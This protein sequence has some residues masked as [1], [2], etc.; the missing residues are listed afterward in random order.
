MR[1]FLI[2]MV[3]F[4]SGMG[5]LLLIPSKQEP[6]P[7]PWETTIMTDGNVKVF[8]IHLGK[9][10]YK[11]AQEIFNIYGKTAVFSQADHE[12]TV[13]AYFNSI[14]LGG[15][16]AKVVLNL[17]VPEQQIQVMLE[18]ATEAKL[19]P[20]GARRYEIHSDDTAHLLASPISAIT[21]IPSVRLDEKMVLNRFGQAEKIQPDPNQA[22]DHVWH[23]PRIGLS[24]T[25][26]TDEKT[27]LQYSV[28]N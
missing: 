26:S 5:A 27:V 9:T 12:S 28:Q 4:V 3:L 8:G 23:Y 7:M 22:S 19:Q 2:G 16:S 20:S 13:E 6:A 14:N 24:I 11:Q 15:L 1:N 25:F 21:Y 10:S 18:H 17:I